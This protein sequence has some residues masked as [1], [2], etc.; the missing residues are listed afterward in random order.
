MILNNEYP[1][2]TPN[3]RNLIVSLL[4]GLFI[5]FFLIFFE[6]FEINISSGKNS[7]ES[8][9]FYGLISTS[10]LIVFL[11]I[12]PFFLPQVFNDECWK[13]KHQMIYCS[14][15]LLV[16]S[17]LNG[18]YTNFINSLSFNWSNYWW[19]INRTFVLGTIPFSFFVLIDYKRRD[20]ANKGVALSIEERK[21]KNE[22]LLKNNVYSIITDLKEEIFSFEDRCFM[23]ASAV[24]NYTDLYFFN[25]GKLSKSTYRISLTAFENQLKT[26]NLLRCHRSFVVNLDKV[27]DVSGNAQGLKLTL[28]D[29]LSIVPVSRRYIQDVKSSILKST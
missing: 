16:I 24:G 20:V 6:P 2:P 15:I 29:G 5:A 7:I 4:F 21:N 3:R 18:L 25:E 8:L 19:I 23:Y 13:V 1:A 28:T 10:V 9:L 22:L 27:I 12:L 14:V 11:N 26:S 17:T